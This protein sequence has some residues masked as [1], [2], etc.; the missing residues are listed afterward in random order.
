[1]GA[2]SSATAAASSA[3]AAF[4]RATSADASKSAAQTAKDQ[5][6]AAADGFSVGTVTTVPPT[7]P[8]SAQITGTAP[9]R[10]ISFSIPRGVT[11]APSIGTVTTGLPQAN[12]GPQGNG[13]PQGIQGPSGDMVPVA[14]PGVATGTVTLISSDLPTTRIWSLTGN[15]TLVLPTPGATKSGTITL[16]LTQDAT[17]SRTITWPAGVKWPDGIA[18]QPAAAANSTSVIHLL[19]TGTMWL[20]LLGGKSFA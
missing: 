17:G 3:S 10:V 14:G 18:Q 5:A 19:W 11:P 20:G 16:V 15:V 2:A 13:G 12:P 6:V 9:A 7:T 8:A 4:D 1:V